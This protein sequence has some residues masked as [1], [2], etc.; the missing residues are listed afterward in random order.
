MGINKKNPTSP[1]PWEFIKSE[2]GPDLKIFKARYD[3]MRNPR[4]GIE[5]ARTVLE[6]VDWVN[7]VAVTPERKVVMVFQYR[8]GTGK[9]TAEV[10]GGMVDPGED[11]LA[12]AKRELREET[13][14]TSRDWTY[15]GAVET[16]PAFLNNLCHH[17]LALDAEKTDDTE[18]GDGEDVVVRL[19]A[20]EQIRSQIASGEMRHVLCLSALSR[21]SDFQLNEKGFLLDTWAAASPDTIADGL[22]NRKKE[23]K[24]GVFQRLYLNIFGK[25]KRLYSKLLHPRREVREKARALLDQ[26]D[27]LWRQGRELAERV[28]KLISFLSG[29]PESGTAGAAEILGIVT[30]ERAIKPLISA[31]GNRDENVR[32]AA[33]EALGKI[34]DGR[35]L[36]PLINALKDK[37]RVSKA[38]EKALWALADESA[39]EPFI[40]ALKVDNPYVQTAAME[41]LCTIG[42][43]RAAASVNVLLH[44]HNEYVRLSAAKTL[45][46]IGTES[47]VPLLIKALEED[48]DR[49]REQAALALGNIG[50]ERAVLSLIQAGTIP[51]TPPALALEK[52]VKSNAPYLSHYPNL[53][54]GRCYRR[55]TLVMPDVTA[56]PKC[57]VSKNLLMGITEVAGVIGGEL[58]EMERKK[59]KIEVPVW[60]EEEKRARFAD[61]NVLVIRENGVENYHLAINALLLELNKNTPQQPGEKIPVS[62]EGKP[63]LSNFELNLLSANF[64]VYY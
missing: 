52:I 29:P 50:D 26:V 37:Y 42:D 57:G 14:Y 36:H 19:L 2:P 5:L 4:N 1:L 27:P 11:S 6:S 18:L 38:A 43:S 44:N 58:L 41:F 53:F 40:E 16:N 51:N 45:G 63:P 55:P 13:G 62:V 61:I 20:P 47:A 8:F 34:G 49:V 28:P 3:T 30:D 48:R 25:K 23:N 12:A 35:A 46:K 39:L 9:I 15:L 60:I 21:V 10:P 32:V 59:D 56:C 33:A 7:V 22:A 17:W 64:D 24:P 31:L 54:C